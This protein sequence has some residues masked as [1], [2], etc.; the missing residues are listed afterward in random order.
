MNRLIGIFLL[1]INRLTI[2]LQNIINRIHKSH[3]Q[4]VLYFI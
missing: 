2:N 1:M 3:V 4:N